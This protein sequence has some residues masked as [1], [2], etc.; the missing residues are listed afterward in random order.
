MYNIYFFVG[1]CFA[2]L[3]FFPQLII[4]QDR[5]GAM[6]YRALQI[7]R[8]PYYLD[9]E[10]QQNIMTEN[11]L[12][13]N[14]SFPRELFTIPVVVH[15][16]WNEA[17]ENI[18]DNQIFSQIDALNT[19]FQLLNE[20]IIQLPEAFIDLA[21]DVG[22]QFCLANLDPDGEQ[23]N[24]ITRTQTEETCIGSAQTPERKKQ[25][26]YTE[27]GGHD[28][29]D[30]EKYLNIWVGNLCGVL[31]RSSFPF[32]AGEAEDGIV[33]DPFAFGTAGAEPP[34][35]LGR[36]AVHEIG[37]YLNLFHI[38]GGSDDFCDDDLVSD[39]PLQR[40]PY[41][42]CPN[43]PVVSCD[44]ED[45]FM[46]FMNYVDDDCM[47]MFTV[48][49]KGRMLAALLGPR[50]SLLSSDGCALIDNEGSAGI[51]DDNVQLNPNPCNGLF[52]LRTDLRSDVLLNIAIF[53]QQGQLLLEFERQSK[54][55]RPIRV[56]GWPTGAYIVKVTSGKQSV[57][58][59]LILI[60]N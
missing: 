40:G 9:L 37:H 47:Y 18:S 45:L 32:Q 10:E 26:H 50:S 51:N 1:F 43:H 17:E 22:I 23:T 35:D 33:V 5:C 57:F 19:D 16:V 34:Y 56:E 42:G 59:K 4:A 38:W 39:T 41:Y 2:F 6:E 54:E 13:A 8:D 12:K 36:T 7:A 30:P 29:W 46:N 15:V 28:A 49:Q 48:G 3:G 25:I 24:G 11:L 53:N 21:A 27:Y 14:P 55:I 31:G 44:S 60:A 58:K 20:D 52:Y